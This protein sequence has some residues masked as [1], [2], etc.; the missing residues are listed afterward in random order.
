MPRADS[1]PFFTYSKHDM[2]Y[3]ASKPIVIIKKM[4]KRYA[5]ACLR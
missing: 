3:E 4:S 2:F 5:V 1:F